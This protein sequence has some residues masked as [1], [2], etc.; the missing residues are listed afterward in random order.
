M[1]DPGGSGCDGTRAAG[2]GAQPTPQIE[3]I[4][5]YSCLRAFVEFVLPAIPVVLRV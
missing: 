2:H 1:S 4:P 5:D 3:L